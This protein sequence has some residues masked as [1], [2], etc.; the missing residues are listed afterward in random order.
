MK[1][2]ADIVDANK[3]MPLKSGTLL[4]LQTSFKEQFYEIAKSIIGQNYDPSK[5]YLLNGCVNSGSGSSYIFST[6]TILYGNQLYIVPA[7]SF[8]TSGGQ[9]PICNFSVTNVVATNYDPVLF[10][11]GTSYNVHYDKIIEISAGASGSG[12]RDFLDESQVVIV[13]NDKSQTITP[14]TGYNLGSN[15][16][17]FVNKN[18]KNQ[19]LIE[20]SLQV[21]GVN[22][23][24]TTAK[25][26]TLPSTYRPLH[27]LIMPCNIYD[28]V[29]FSQ[30]AILNIKTN[31]DMF[32]IC[33]QY[34]TYPLW[35]TFIQIYFNATYYI[36]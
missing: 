15:A 34:Q 16:G 25:I 9:V 21:S 13:N 7:V 23:N 27:E 30:S 11:D 5:A 17:I 2:I 10:T 35:P 32:V 8:T 3:S 22:V 31:G 20:G 28:T 18:S 29:N 33:G 24:M 36:Q 4:H 14:S 26:C 6:G 12:I 1:Y 19:V